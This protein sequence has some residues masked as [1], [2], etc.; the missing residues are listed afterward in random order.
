MRLL[1]VCRSTIRN[2]KTYDGSNV[3]EFQVTR[4]RDCLNQELVLAL[5]IERGLILHS[6]QQNYFLISMSSIQVPRTCYTDLGRP[7]VSRV[8]YGQSWVEH[9]S[10]DDLVRCSRDVY[11]R[12]VG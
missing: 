12:K 9:S 3:C 6:L 11:G 10:C 8:L 7:H 1:D 5:G 2:D 4:N